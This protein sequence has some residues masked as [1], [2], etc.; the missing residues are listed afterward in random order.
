[1]RKNPNS[2]FVVQVR[3]YN[4]YVYDSE[5]DEHWQEAGLFR[6]KHKRYV[7]QHFNFDLSG[8]GM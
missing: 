8:N 7:Q 5:L 2:F 6:E 3:V 4:I 1:M